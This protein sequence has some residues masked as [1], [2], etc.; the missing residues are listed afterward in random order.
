MIDEVYAAMTTLG[1]LHYCECRNSNRPYVA[2]RVEHGVM[3]CVTCGG[4]L[5]TLTERAAILE[6]DAHFTRPEAERLASVMFREGMAR[7]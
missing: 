1:P 2:Y 4:E 3:E 5:V 6:Y 7:E